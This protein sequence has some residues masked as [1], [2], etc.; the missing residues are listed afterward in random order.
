MDS[1]NEESL[2]GRPYI[3]TQPTMNSKGQKENPIVFVDSWF[4][5]FTGYEVHEI[6]G[7]NC[8]F[9]QA[10]PLSYIK[11]ENVSEEEE[12]ML[13]EKARETVNRI[14]KSG[15]PEVITVVNY[16]KDGKPF[17]NTFMVEVHRDKRNNNINFF[18][19]KH[20]NI[21]NLYSDA[22][23]SPDSPVRDR[24]SEL[25]SSNKIRMKEVRRVPIRM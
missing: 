15:I 1:A 24:N 25:K 4:L 14:A 5:D 8:N 2:D 12:A 20:L 19:A 11:P 9:L 23:Y 22:S 7:R 17:R 3:V 16:T 18:V 6:L 13:T 10:R 21:E